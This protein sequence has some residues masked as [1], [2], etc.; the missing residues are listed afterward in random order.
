MP[1]STIY[2]SDGSM[3]FSMGVDSGRVTLV[4]SQSNPNGLRRDQL[5]WLTNGTVRGGGITQRP[6]WKYL[7]TIHDGS[8]IYQ[9][10]T[11]YEPINNLPYWMGSIGGR[12]YKVDLLSGAAP[13]DLTTLYGP[14]LD[15]PSA[16]EQAFFCQGEEFL[17]IQ[18]GDNAT[19]PLFWYDTGS[20]QL[21]RRSLG[22]VGV[23]DPNNEI[24]PATA[25]DYYQQRLWYAQQRTYTAGDIVKGPSG[26][27]PFNF[28]D[29]ILHVTENPLAI[30]GDGFTVPTFAG[31]IRALAHSANLDDNLGQTPLFVFTR[32]DVYALS[33]PITRL[34]WTKAGDGTGN[35]VNPLQR[36][37]QKRYGTSSDRSIVAVNGDLYY[38]TLEPGVRSL[39]L[40][41]R[42][43]NQ[44]GNTPISRNVRR[45]LD[46]ND[47]SLLR[48]GS[49]MLFD[50]R[51]WQT[52][53]P[54]Q[55][56]VGVAHRGAV[57]LDFDIVSSFQ[58]KLSGTS[59]P[60]WEGLQEGL[61]I[62]QF[63]SHEF[64]GLERAFAVVYSEKDGTIQL[65]ELSQ[66][67]RFENGDNRVGWTIEF[68]S[69]D[70]GNA[71]ALKELQ[72]MRL[73]VDR[74]YGEVE[75]EAYY[76]PEFDPCWQ[77]WGRW[78]K[79]VAKNSEEDLNN[80]VSYPLTEFGEGFALPFTL[81]H[82]PKDCNS[83][84]QRPAFIGRFFQTKV[85]IKGFC[86]VR[87]LLLYSSESKETMYRDLVC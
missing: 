7:T 82:P 48:F 65:W 10:G 11:I 47:R 20:T 54:F 86:R 32:K 70:F 16:V 66:R 50:N 38:Q 73:W 43:F 23:G 5:A 81:P 60:A 58:D 64:G 17:V 68:P 13:I 67:D 51:V 83:M 31:N 39:A 27:A 45:A 62:L 44:F 72:A 6:T 14:G 9:G 33:V 37:V 85:L 18:A 22:I 28:R 61:S 75:F 74:L 59:I 3:E 1:D 40:A 41:V 36:V 46:F 21:L 24:P 26:T 63:H 76:R 77:W 79:C 2:K 29:A 19:K 8:A 87:G 53:L 71:T 69:F 56:P 80:P 52:C 35:T 57:T 4:Q 84:G 34:D 42:F 25:M 55:T 30:G 49:G 78:R 15:N 12:I